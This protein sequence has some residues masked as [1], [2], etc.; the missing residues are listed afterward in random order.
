MK[1]KF[2]RFLNKIT[3]LLAKKENEKITLQRVAD[4][5]YFL[6]QY[7]PEKDE[8]WNNKAIIK[9]G[10]Y[11]YFFL[12]DETLP[13]IHFVLPEIPL[14]VYIGG[15]ET[16]SWPEAARNGVSRPVWEYHQGLLTIYQ[17]YLGSLVTSESTRAPRVLI[18]DWDTSTNCFELY[19]TIKALYGPED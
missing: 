15:I 10:I 19:K 11:N 8:F 3:G 2:L 1:E 16:A 9:D 14:F 17:E 7:L 18:I 12:P 6:H 5:E 13:K 4:V